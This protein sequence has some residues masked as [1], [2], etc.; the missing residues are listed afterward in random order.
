MKKV[1]ISIALFMLLTYS[2]SVSLFDTN[3]GGTWISNTGFN[4]MDGQAYNLKYI[5]GGYS[6]R[7]E[8]SGTCYVIDG[9][10]LWIYE[11]TGPATGPFIDVIRY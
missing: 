11:A 9:P 1:I 7:C 10:Y 5:P 2:L 4:R 6:F 8:G 3:Q